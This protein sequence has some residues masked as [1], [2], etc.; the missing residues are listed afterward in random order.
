M[1]FYFHCLVSPPPPS[2]V[3]FA[4]Y[5]SGQTRRFDSLS[6]VFLFTNLSL[7]L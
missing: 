4:F 1:N 6:Q 3:H 7:T 5:F 2:Y